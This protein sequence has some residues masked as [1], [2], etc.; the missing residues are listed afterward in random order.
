MPFHVEVS[1]QTRDTSPAVESWYPTLQ[2]V[3]ATEPHVVSPD[4]VYVI[5]PFPGAVSTEQ[6]FSENGIYTL[7][8]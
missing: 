4:G 1:P 8:S 3:L 6:F 5:E 7:N 2:D